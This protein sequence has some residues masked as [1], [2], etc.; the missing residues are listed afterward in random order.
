MFACNVPLG[1][2]CKDDILRNLKKSANIFIKDKAFKIMMIKKLLIF[3]MISLKL[4]FL[5]N[6]FLN[7]IFNL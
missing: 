7:N 5:I 4:F 6:M 3:P 2:Y 1:F